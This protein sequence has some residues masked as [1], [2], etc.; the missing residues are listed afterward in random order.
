MRDVTAQEDLS[1]INELTLIMLLGNKYISAV[2]HNV[3]KQFISF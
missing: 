3:Y 1:F 2:S